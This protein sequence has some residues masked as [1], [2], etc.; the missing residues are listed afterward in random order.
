MA[1]EQTLEKLAKGLETTSNLAQS[2][3]HEIKESNQD[4]A[5]IKAELNTLRENVKNLNSIIQDNNSGMSVLTRIILVEKKLDT[6]DSY[7]KEHSQNHETL[8]QEQIETIRFHSELDRRIK[9]I[10][11]A[12]RNI[13]KQA[14]EEHRQK[15]DSIQK[16]KDLSFEK[17]KQ[18]E[19]IK[20]ARAS[21]FWKIVT[22]IVVGAVSWAIGFFL[23]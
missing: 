10:E 6:I 18:K 4:F 15:L 16:E 20:G 17:Q 22:V 14:E 8:K 5:S 9:D 2:L 7:I 1:N 12:I 23:K 19:K 21:M 13:K 3:L 11:S